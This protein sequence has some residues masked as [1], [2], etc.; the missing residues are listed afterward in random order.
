M[1]TYFDLSTGKICSWDQNTQALKTSRCDYLRIKEEPN[2]KPL[3]VHPR[4]FPIF[5]NIIMEEFREIAK[6]AKNPLYLVSADFDTLGRLMWIFGR[7]DKKP[8]DSFATR[9]RTFEAQIDS[10]GAADMYNYGDGTLREGVRSMLTQLANQ[11][12]GQS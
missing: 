11:A 9:N 3:H 10:A 1:N 6:T 12:G 2:E 5:S 8:A 4:F 7:E